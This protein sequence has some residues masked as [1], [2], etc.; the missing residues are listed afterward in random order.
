MT[1]SDASASPTSATWMHEIFCFVR[2]QTG[3]AWKAL[4]DPPFLAFLK[5][6]A[7]LARVQ[8]VYWGWKLQL[9]AWIPTI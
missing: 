2:Y 8:C 3:R 5:L 1:A 9:I 6:T 4:I 7:N